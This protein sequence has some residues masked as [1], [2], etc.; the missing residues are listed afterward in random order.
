MF[1]LAKET[2]AAAS[3]AAKLSSSHGWLW[4]VN[5]VDGTTNFVHGMPLCMP[6]VAAI[7][8]GDVVVG[9]IYDLHR[10]EVFYT[11][12]GR[13]ASMNEKRIHM[14]LQETFGDAICLI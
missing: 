1:L 9:G 8:K 3:D 4:I 2:S 6:S 12:R 10:E 14:G 11:V 13:G 7:Y 5:P